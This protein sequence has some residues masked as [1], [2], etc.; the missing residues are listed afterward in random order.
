MGRRMMDR[1]SEFALDV[2]LDRG[3]GC[4]DQRFSRIQTAIGAARLDAGGRR[5]RLHR[6]KHMCGPW[7]VFVQDASALRD[8]G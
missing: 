8:I 1:N 3:L 6:H 2:L 4:R 7:N 5:R